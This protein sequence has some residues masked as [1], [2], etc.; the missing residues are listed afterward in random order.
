MEF[1]SKK[2]F[3]NE[4]GRGNYGFVYKILI[5]KFSKSRE[6]SGRTTSRFDNKE[7][8]D[9]VSYRPQ[10]LPLAML[11]IEESRHSTTGSL[12]HRSSPCL[13]EV[14]RELQRSRRLQLCCPRWQ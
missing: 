11:L 3:D 13:H 6:K 7:F 1:D 10:I 4:F 5:M 9:N 8:L 14:H 2:S 12:S